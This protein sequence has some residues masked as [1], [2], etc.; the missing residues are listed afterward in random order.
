MKTLLKLWPLWLVTFLFASFMALTAFVNSSMLLESFGISETAL[1]ILYSLGSVC[2]LGFVLILPRFFH[3]HMTVKSLLAS[4]LIL[5]SASTAGLVFLPQTPLSGSILF[6]LYL[7]A[8]S[9]VLYLLDIVVGHYSTPGNTGVMRGWYM[10][11]ISIAWVIAPFAS[12]YLIEVL[13]G[14]D[15][16][17]IIAGVLLSFA[18][19]IVGLVYV[20]FSPDESHSTTGLLSD[21]KDFFTN[22]NLRNIFMTNS[23]LQTFYAVMVIYS[24]IYLNEVIGLSWEYIGIIFAIMLMAFVLFDYPLGYLADH[25]IGEKEILT[26]GLMIMSGTTLLIAFVGEV[27]WL[28]WALLLFGTRTGAAATEMMNESFFFKHVTPDDVSFIAYY[29]NARPLAYIL[30]PLVMSFSLGVFNLET[31]HIFII[32]SV[33]VVLG[34]F[35][36]LGLEDT[37]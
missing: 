7:M 26:L 24:P 13:G 2:A 10:T 29:R 9:A 37:R 8:T 35:W 3:R 19:I 15:I 28:W 34:V 23:L 22:K 30:A 21:I 31:R 11:I 18:A 20:P 14:Y 17:Y 4:I 32:L 16:V 5:G 25:Y 6:V 27:H 12:G 36:S 33:M 1:G